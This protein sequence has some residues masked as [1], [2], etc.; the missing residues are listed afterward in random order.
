MSISLDREAISDE[1]VPADEV[2]GMCT[3][4]V[5]GW[6]V[7]VYS[8]GCDGFVVAENVAGWEWRLVRISD[9]GSRYDKISGIACGHLEHLLDGFL[10]CIEE[11][12]A[13]F[14]MI[15]LSEQL[16]MAVDRGAI[17]VFGFRLA[18]ECTSVT[19]LHWF[20]RIVPME[21]MLVR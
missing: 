16:F 18:E 2:L 12:R 8:V 9:G 4:I 21:L 6:R 20:T 7:G 5:N 10:L 17:Q 15:F 11:I 13:E 1:R 19:N 3:S 14:L